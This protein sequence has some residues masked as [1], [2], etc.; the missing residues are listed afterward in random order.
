[1]IG[2]PPTAE[3]TAMLADRLASLP[4]RL[5]VLLIAG[6]CSDVVDARAMDMFRAQAPHADVVQVAKA[7]HMVAGDRN[8]AFGD[9]IS[10]FLAKIREATTA[11]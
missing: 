7:G 11:G 4:P 1:V 5:P 2:T 8:D 6:A 9:A 10:G 3:T